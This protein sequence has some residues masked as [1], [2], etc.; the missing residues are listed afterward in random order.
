M[1]YREQLDDLR[2]TQRER[3]DDA[4]PELL[5]APARKAGTEEW[6]RLPM[7][8]EDPG[9]RFFTAADTKGRAALLRALLLP[10]LYCYSPAEA[11][12]WYFGVGS[13]SMEELRMPGVRRFGRED[14]E[15]FLAA[16]RDEQKRRRELMASFSSR[17]FAAHCFRGITGVAYHRGLPRLILLIDGW[18]SL[19]GALGREGLRRLRAEAEADGLT[20]LAIGEGP[21]P[22]LPGLHGAVLRPFG[23]AC[24]S[25][26]LSEGGEGILAVPTAEDYEAVLA[27]LREKAERWRRMQEEAERREAQWRH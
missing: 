12:I 8:L 11:E 7:G 16:L 5:L 9:F 13:E 6:I 24:F 4:K 19:A 2:R 10:L 3:W 15:G 17:D 18:E 23:E 27:T 20:L 1:N 26:V 21:G 14:P 22:V 25:L